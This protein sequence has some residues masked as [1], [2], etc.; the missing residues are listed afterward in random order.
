MVFVFSKVFILSC[1]ET[2]LIFYLCTRV[3]VVVWVPSLTYV[4]V[5]YV[6][7]W[8]HHFP[9][10]T[11]PSPA[12][13][14]AGF[15]RM[16]GLQGCCAVG[17]YDA[18]MPQ[19]LVWKGMGGRQGEKAAFGNGKNQEIWETKTPRVM[20]FCRKHFEF[21][22]ERNYLSVFFCMER[23]NV[24]VARAFEHQIHCSLSNESKVLILLGFELNGI[25]WWDKVFWNLNLD[26]TK[27]IIEQKS[28]MHEI[29]NSTSFTC[30]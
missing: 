6:E 7:S 23:G 19:W 26:Q 25:L 22:Y 4:L 11:V 13:V 16:P 5:Y 29:Y 24:F 28:K 10:A 3:G 12:E 18:S 27:K 30:W 20:T 9:I 15:V 17:C 14:R 8:H 21:W 2:L 1:Q